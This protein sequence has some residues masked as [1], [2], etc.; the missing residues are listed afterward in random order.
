M[1]VF[2]IDPFLVDSDLA[3]IEAAIDKFAEGLTDWRA[4]RASGRLGC[5]DRRSGRGSGPKRRDVHNISA[6]IILP[7]AL[8]LLNPA[9]VY[10]YG[11][12]AIEPRFMRYCR[13]AS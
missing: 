7:L 2:P 12:A 1:V 6:H 4:G 8:P 9:V 13:F 10:P 3:P 5:L 11:V